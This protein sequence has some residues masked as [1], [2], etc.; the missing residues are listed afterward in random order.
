MPHVASVALRLQ[1]LRLF[2][3]PQ[4]LR[5]HRLAERGRLINS[6]RESLVCIRGFSSMKRESTG[7]ILSTVFVDY[8]NIYLSLKR[9]NEDAAKRFAKD[10]GAW[11]Q[12]IL[13]GELITPTS[14]YFAPAERRIAR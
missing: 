10:C 4:T 11:L 9:K 7:P 12:G 2:N 5:S 8:D 13:S 3:R 14:G 6:S 1:S